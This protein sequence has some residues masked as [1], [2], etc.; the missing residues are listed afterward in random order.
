MNLL[1]LSLDSM[2]GFDAPRTLKI[3]GNIG[4]REVTILVDSGASHNFIAYEVVKE[5]NL[6]IEGQTGFAMMVGNRQRIMGQGVCRRV[7][8]AVQGVMI[9][10]DFF[11]FELGGTDM[12][13]GV[14][15]LVTLGK[16]DA[17]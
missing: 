9:T 15:W 16:V 8:V 5:L 7:T 17:N 4:D 14:Q 1:K 3:W 11:P 10:Q 6:L 12:V 13:L 2:I